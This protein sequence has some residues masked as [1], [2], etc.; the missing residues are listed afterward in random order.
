MEILASGRGGRAR[1]L[2][3]AREYVEDLKNDQGL[4]DVL[5]ERRERRRVVQANRALGEHV[6]KLV[7]ESLEAGD[8]V[9]R[10]TGVGS[11][12]E[13]HQETDDVMNLEVTRSGRT[14]LVEVKA[15]RDQQGVR[16]TTKQAKEAVKEKSRFLLCVVTVT[17]EEPGPDGRTGEHAVRGEYR[18]CRSS[19]V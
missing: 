6:E 12:F 19:S 1:L 8:F 18:W 5:T 7:K 15:T 4:P 3:Y 9:V 13:I 2:N 14:W 11:D 17:A 10:R 16:M